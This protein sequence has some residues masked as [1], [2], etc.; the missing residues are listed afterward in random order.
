MSH[1]GVDDKGP[2]PGVR[3]APQVGSDRIGS[4]KGKQRYYF[5]DEEKT[6][7]GGQ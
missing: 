1:H 5:R 7:T 2:S 6:I 3:L 4:A